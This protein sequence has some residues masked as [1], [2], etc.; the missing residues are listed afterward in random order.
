M[1]PNARANGNE[2]IRHDSPFV[3]RCKYHLAPVSVLWHENYHSGWGR[4][5]M[6]GRMARRDT[7]RE[8]ATGGG[9]R[10][11]HH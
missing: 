3:L 1:I 5:E 10:E 4:K 9:V 7:A 8:E 6:V 2:L 11:V